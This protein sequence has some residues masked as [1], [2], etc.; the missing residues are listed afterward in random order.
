M[1]D[2]NPQVQPAGANEVSSTEETPATEAKSTSTEQPQAPE[3]AQ[4]PA[5]PE[6]PAAP[7]KPPAKPPVKTTQ[8]ERM[9]SAIGYIAFLGVVT[10]AMMPKSEFC[11]K[12]AS[13]GIVIFALWFVGLIL[14][15]LPI[16]L[17]NGLGFLI[18]VIATALAIFGIVKSISS[19]ELKLPVLSDLAKMVPVGAIVGKMTGKTPPPGAPKPGEK[20]AEAPEAPAGANEES[21]KEEA[22]ASEAQPEAPK[23]EAPAEP[24]AEEPPKED[25]SPA[26]SDPEEKPETPPQQ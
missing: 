9:W 18:I 23:S 4:Q 26:A 16:A 15:A 19:Y 11:K 24:K 2:D 21:S 20:P 1:S 8:E 14:L 12:H 25:P 6:K 17:V 7:P 5:Q 3:Q 10:L 22:P 13:Q